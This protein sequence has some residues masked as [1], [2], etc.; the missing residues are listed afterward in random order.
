[1]M[2]NPAIVIGL[3]CVFG[4][5]GAG[6]AWLAA[7]RH[8][9]P[10]GDVDAAIGAAVETLRAERAAYLQAALDTSLSVASSKLGDQLE[11]GK[12]VINRERLAVS[13]QVSVMAD[14]LRRVAGLVSA[15]QQERAEQHGK[16]SIGME[17]AAAVTASLAATTQS[18]KE[19]LAS[20]TAR[21]QWGERMAEDVLRMAGFVDGINYTK[22]ARL[23]DGG[24]PDYSFIMPHGHQVH[25]DVKFPA[26]NYLRWLDTA[27]G[28]DRDAALK[29]FKRDVRARVDELGTR[30][31]GAGADS[32]DYVLA[33]IPNESI[34]G[35]LH[36]HDRDLIDVA[37]SKKVI[38][39]SPTSLF[40]VLAVIRQS[41]DNFLVERRSDELL[42]GL[43][44]LQ[45]QWRRFG[46]TVDKVGRSLVTAQ[47]A[48]DDLNGP[49]RR[50]LDKQLALVDELRNADG[51]A[52]GG[53]DAATAAEPVNDEMSRR[54][55]DRVAP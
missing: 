48:F 49:R 23:A 54:R 32:V 27:D 4:A 39:C 11:V 19:A 7:S 36:E 40:A 1:M 17:Q 46:E 2:I 38:L 52:E 24:I 12:H 15:L 31:Y 5:I 21:G 3:A 22:Q 53:V 50:A 45:D 43:A 51:G 9:S 14:E 26:S 33:F 55:L 37:L 16:L 41:V 20:P 44:G 10:G 8:P 18:L 6:I 30:G 25:M 47:T 13:D 42:A 34:Y 29:L 28:A 35:F